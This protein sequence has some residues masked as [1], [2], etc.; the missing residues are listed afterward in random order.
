M[1]NEKLEKSLRFATTNVEIDVK[2]SL[3]ASAIGT[4]L[5]EICNKLIFA[6]L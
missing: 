6:I 3:L 1:I 4:L 2:P 5:I